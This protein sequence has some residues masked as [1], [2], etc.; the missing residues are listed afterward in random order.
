[1]LR[2]NKWLCVGVVGLV[3]MV[4]LSLAGPVSAVEVRE[5]AN[6][7]VAQGEVIDDDLFIGGT[8]V[9]VD[10]TVNGDLFAAGRDVVVNG[11]VNGSLAIAGQSLTLNGKV[12][13]S[14]Y[15]GGSVLI[16]GPNARVERNAFVGAYS[17]STRL[18]S[19]VGRD[20]LIGAY[21]ALLSGEVGRDVK[22]GLGALELR[23]NVGRD[24]SIEVGDPRSGS[25][26]RAMM[27]F[28]GVE[29]VQA[30][31]PGL[32][33]SSEAKIGGK[34][35]YR[36]GVDQASGI[37]AKPAGGVAFQLTEQAVRDQ[38]RRNPVRVF[39]NWLLG[40]AR[41]LITLLV[42]G[43]L[44]LW[45]L[46]TWIPRLTGKVQQ[47]P[48]PA[49]GWGLVVVVLG[50]VGAVVLAI[51]ILLLALLFWV[52][53]IG[54]LAG[55]VLGVGFS[56]L[57]V[58]WTLFGL[59]VSYGSKLVVAYLAGEWIAQ[60][61]GPRLAE[62]RGWALVIGVVIYVILRGIPILGWLVGLAVTL[63]GLGAMW[64]VYR[65]QR[66]TAAVPTAAA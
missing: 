45:L 7:V 12:T 19:V 52:V 17:L 64:L 5:G 61:L 33:V 32:R 50:Y 8:T 13:G 21:Q 24:V 43:A 51:V 36:S 31:D 29:G 59:I 9:V 41:E 10:G 22:A 65:E 34:L 44:A 35:A 40:R 49:L 60:R 58:V 55:T 23:G 18:G 25:A 38:A 37:A 16:L 46:P 54:G 53:T 3:V 26:Q 56:S 48:L 28:Y 4:L 39:G 57:A 2:N 63:I 1:M 47:Q 66:A 14:V 20:L 42:L 62:S 30:V 15:A 11:T 27:P 6:V